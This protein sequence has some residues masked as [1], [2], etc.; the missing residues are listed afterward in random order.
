MLRL[1]NV[2]IVL[3]ALSFTMLNTGC[4]YFSNSNA[5][6]N[7]E[8]STLFGNPDGAYL[9][10]KIWDAKAEEEFSAWIEQLG[11]ELD[12]GSCQ[13]LGECLINRQAN[14]LWSTEDQNLAL[15][16]DSTDV[17]TLLRAYFSYKTK[18]PFQYVSKVEKN[19]SQENNTPTEF[20]SFSDFPNVNTMFQKIAND[21]HSD[22][23]RLAP[24]EQFGDTYPIDVTADSLKPGV[25]FHDINGGTFIVYKVE[26]NGDI[27]LLNGHSDNR[28]TTSPFGE[29]FTRGNA[30]QGGGFR[31]WRW[32]NI[33]TVDASAKRYKLDRNNNENSRYFNA[34]SQYEIGN[35]NSA[36]QAQRYHAW[37]KSRIAQPEAVVQPVEEFY[38]ML[39]SLCADTQERIATVNKT[40]AAE[41]YKKS[42]PG[43]LPDNIFSA[44]GDWE[45]HSTPSRDA[46]LRLG[47]QS[48]HNYA[49]QSLES[50]GKSDSRIQFRGSQ[51]M[52]ARAFQNTWNALAT[53]DICKFT[54][55]NSLNQ[56]T[57]LT[58]DHIVQRLYDISFDPYH[59]PEMRWGA[60]PQRGSNLATVDFGTCVRDSTKE[61]WYWKESRLRLV[62]Q[63]I[64]SKETPYTLDS[65]NPSELNTPSLLSEIIAKSQASLP[66]KPVFELAPVLAI[67]PDGVD[68]AILSDKCSSVQ[69]KNPRK[70]SSTRGCSFQ[71]ASQKCTVAPRYNELLAT[72]KMQ[73]KIVSTHATLLEE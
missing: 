41:V 43:I 21:V 47:F 23:Y 37:I 67:T 33:H 34:K 19:L 55:K 50:L 49:K 72:A 59:C 51:R 5:T 35:D 20:S 3:S 25:V 16:S 58:L 64:F 71:P 10:D 11:R 52:L 7:T 8:F 17:P 24:N 22:F 46:R 29:K 48:L 53:Q 18:R 38:D 40:F 1:N 30:P 27:G 42:H 26:A 45:A 9:A 13:K 28:I 57:S 39:K 44:N 56:P 2:A 31:A 54:Y 70:C 61:E 6:P 15:F 69:D 62:T 66:T 32:T 63:R 73:G 4:R 36:N 68:L 14:K 60:K 12:L 65:G